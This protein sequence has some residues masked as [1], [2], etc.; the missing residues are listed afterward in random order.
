MSTRVAAV[1]STVASHKTRVWVWTFP[2]PSRMFI[3]D[4]AVAAD[5]DDADVMVV[6]TKIITQ[7]RCCG[8]RAAPGYQLKLL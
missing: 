3:P 2:S 7:F 8:D 6:P 5:D 1:E 4:E